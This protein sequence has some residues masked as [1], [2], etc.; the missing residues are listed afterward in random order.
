MDILKRLKIRTRLL[1]IIIGSS[2]ALVVLGLAA[3]HHL[4]SMH[5]EFALEFG[6][7]TRVSDSQEIRRDFTGLHMD[8]QT[9]AARGPA[10]MDAGLPGWRDRGQAMRKEMDALAKGAMT[11]S[12]QQGIKVFSEAF[13]A[14]LAQ[15]AEDRRP[16]PAALKPFYD[17]VEAAGL[18]L[19]AA[20]LKAAQ[21]AF[22]ANG[23]IWRQAMAVNIGL[24]AFFITAG[25]GAGVLISLS[26]DSSLAGISRRMRDLAEG[27]GDL[28]QRINSGGRDEL[29]HMA[30]FID[31]FIQKAHDTVAHS[32]ATA[33]QTA[34]ASRELSGISSELAGNVASEWE[35]ARNS[36]LLMHD[37]ARDLDATETMSISTTEALESTGKLLDAFVATLTG[38]GGVVVSESGKQAELAERMQELSREA[39]GINEVLG[40]LAEIAD[41]TNLLALNANIE[42][43]HAQEAGKGF[44]VV[45]GEIRKLAVRTQ[46]SLNEVDANVKAVV[47][48][49]EAVSLETARASRQM[50]D[51]SGRTEGLMQDA[52]TTGQRLR[53]SVAT[54]AEL[55]AKTTSNAT[56]TRD[57]ITT[58]NSLV[59]L[60]TRN[61]ASAE[62]VDSVSVDLAGKAD[63]LQRTLNHFKVKE[64]R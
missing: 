59:D 35:L 2:A 30:G 15:A 48:G 21:E 18:R 41:Q 46:A 43:A 4:G 61:K 28:T 14:Y 5:R 6:T 27:E 16:D 32:V 26:I 34:A 56:R 10:A 22:D 53:G 39:Q 54:A 13:D 49:I 47:D 52:D 40:I 38:V 51:L 19:K 1:C 31:R 37:V 36:S 57:L 25:A 12:Q 23:T 24:L 63:D 8:L 50:L 9:L 33:G 60:S 55:V 58:M 62:G 45:A 20:N 44:A 17:A 64:G 3:I 29:A 7:L 42:A 11:I